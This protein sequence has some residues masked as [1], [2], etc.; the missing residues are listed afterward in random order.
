MSDT[1]LP[2]AFAF[3]ADCLEAGKP[4]PDHRDDYDRAEVGEADGNITTSARGT[5]A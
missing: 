3:C 5:A 1:P 2:D 4:C